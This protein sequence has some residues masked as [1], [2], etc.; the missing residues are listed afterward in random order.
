MVCQLCKTEQE[1]IDQFITEK[2]WLSKKVIDI[3]YDC[4]YDLYEMYP[5]ISGIKFKHYGGTFGRSVE[6][7]DDFKDLDKLRNLW[8][9][10]IEKEKREKKEKRK[11]KKLIAEA[12]RRNKKEKQEKKK[13]LKVSIIQLLNDKS[14][15]IK[16]VS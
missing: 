12:S 15:K 16:L 9:K 13:A 1:Y 8:K 3:C 5:E 14:I 7:I 10:H 6:H 2:G 11:R 4:R